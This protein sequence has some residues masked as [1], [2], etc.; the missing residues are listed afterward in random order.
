MQTQHKIMIY[1]Y[2]IQKIYDHIYHT[3]NIRDCFINKHIKLNYLYI[4]YVR[5]INKILLANLLLKNNKDLVKIKY[6]IINIYYL[7]GVTLGYY[8]NVVT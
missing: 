8:I 4:S 5:Q 7:T 6:I 3:C 2:F 1:W